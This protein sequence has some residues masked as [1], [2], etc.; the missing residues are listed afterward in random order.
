MSSCLVNLLPF[1]ITYNLL[2]KNP[3]V[4]KFESFSPQFSREDQMKKIASVDFLI[5]V[6]TND[7]ERSEYFSQS[8]P[9][10][11]RTNFFFVIDILKTSISDINAD[12]N[13]AYLKFRNTDK[14]YYCNN[15]RTREDISGKF[16]YNERLSRNCY[17]KV[18]IPSNKIVKLS[19]TYTKT[20]IFPLTR[21]VI[22][23]SNPASG[24]PSPLRLWFSI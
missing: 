16:Y 13:G 8:P 7:P 18:Y 2:E 23:V 22:Q 10:V 21:T 4:Q 12:D 15:D 14:F 5:H 3:S 24:P 11:I 1:N 9:K 17:R 19:H 6:L 20:K